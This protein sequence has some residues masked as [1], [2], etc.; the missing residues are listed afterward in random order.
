MLLRCYNRDNRVSL[1]AIMA[2]MEFRCNNRDNRVSDMVLDYFT[3]IRIW[4][5]AFRCNHGVS[6][7]TIM[8]CLVLVE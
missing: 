8:A 7:S 6:L 4:L 2:S 5:M 1:Y 3:I